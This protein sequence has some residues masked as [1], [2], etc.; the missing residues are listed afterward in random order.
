MVRPFLIVLLGYIV[1]FFLASRGR[2]DLLFKI[3]LLTAS[4]ELF[5]EVGY[6]F[7]LGKFEFTYRRASEF[8]LFLVSI[9]II[10]KSVFLNKRVLKYCFGLLIIL[11]VSS[12]LLLI[13]PSN[14]PV[15]NINNSWE[16][17]LMQEKSI[18]HPEF[19]SFV[20]QQTLQMIIYITALFAMYM[21]FKRDDYFKLII[22]FSKIIKFF[23]VLGAFELILKNANQ[24][25]NYGK[26]VEFIFGF[27]ESTIYEART[28]GFGVELT[29]LT[30]EASHYA[31]M[32]FMCIIILFSKYSINK[33]KHDIKWIVLGFV[34]LLFCMSFSTVLFIS[35]IIA[36]YTLY[37][38]NLFE[39]N[40]RN[41]KKQF[42]I[43]SIIAIIIIVV[44]SVNP[45]SISSSSDDFF[46]RRISSL[47]E[48]KDVIFNGL[49]ETEN[50]AL[51]WSNRVRLLSVFMTLKAFI[52]R[53]LLG[54]GFGSITCHGATAM[55]LAGTGIFGTY[56]WT[57]LNFFVGSI[58][59]PN[60]NK[61][62]FTYTIVIF[63]LVNLF[64]SFALRPFHELYTF[65]FAISIALLL[66]RPR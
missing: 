23:F 35:A 39:Q 25:E 14:A 41:I 11:I 3:V 5:I 64:N 24:V 46:S 22:A 40:K 28:R 51:E 57:K 9:Y 19:S 21:S 16:E 60:L 18:S 53:P 44:V 61:K 56:L 32:L 43:A 1:Y 8:L 12:I 52:Y 33:S 27:S 7:K 4:V 17:I 42:L 59:S 34:L 10:L 15:G 36:I 66:N 63:L 45:A 37:K 65:L 13:F 49:W 54:Y 58:I 62:Y 38:W 47:L 2:K 6:F 31:Y 29:G 20:V 26:A 48:E 50:T 30:K 55:M